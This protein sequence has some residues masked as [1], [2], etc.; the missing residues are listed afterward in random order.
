MKMYVFHAA[1]LHTDKVYLVAGVPSQEFHVPVPYYLIKHEKGYVFYD[2]GHNLASVEDAEG[3]LPAPIYAGYGPEIYKEGYILN[4]LE[5]AGVKPEEIMYVVCS[6]LHFDHCGGMGFFPNATY[7]VQKE[8]LAYANNPDPFMQ[9]VYYKEDFNKGLN[10]LV[11]DGWNDNRYDIFGDGKLVIYF[12]PGHTPGH[13]SL[14]VNLED[15]GPMILTGDACYTADNLD[16]LKLSGLACD[17]SAYVKN[18]K[19]FQDMRKRGIKVVIGHD[20]EQWETTKK[21]P[22]FYC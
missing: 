13:Q 9:L 4:A 7:I 14:L 12:T 15:S 3:Y 18:L 16:E 21:F 11:L 10:W 22:E 1:T 20:P 6:H 19:M 8:E 5:K 17:N 2:T